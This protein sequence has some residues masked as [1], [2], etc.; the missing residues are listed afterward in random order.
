MVGF[1]Y[2]LLLLI[3]KILANC[4]ASKKQIRDVTAIFD[5]AALNNRYILPETD[6]HW[7]TR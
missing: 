3:V 6:A 4:V 1:S 5:F 7:I 2:K